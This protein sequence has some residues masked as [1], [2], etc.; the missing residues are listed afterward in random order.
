MNEWHDMEQGITKK[1]E[2]A[3]VIFGMYGDAMVCYWT[4]QCHDNMQNNSIMRGR[5]R[6]RR[7]T[8]NKIEQPT[9]KQSV[10]IK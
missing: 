5:K 3:L 8:Q 9:H 10:I 7:R 6:R 1:K 2:M 4:D